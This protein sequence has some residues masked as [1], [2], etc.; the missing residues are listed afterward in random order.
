MLNNA[1]PTHTL[2]YSIIFAI[3][4]KLTKFKVYNLFVVVK[5]ISNNKV[6]NVNH[7]L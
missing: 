2:I 7:V 5:I 1:K 6:N 3:F 4:V